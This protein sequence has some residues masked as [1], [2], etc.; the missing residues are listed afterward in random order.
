MTNFLTPVGSQPRGLVKIN[1]TVIDGWL[2]FDVDNNS[3]FSADTFRLTLAAGALP[4]TMDAV[5]FCAQ[6]DMYVELFIGFP[7]DPTNYGPQDLTSWIYGQ[8]DEIDYDPVNNTITLTGRDLTRVFIDTKTTQ[9]W[10]NLTSSQIAT[11]LAQ[12][13]G[14]TPVVTAT[15]IKAG[16]LYEIDHVN[17]TDERS[18]W[19][20]LNYLANAEGFIVYVRGQSLYFQPAPA[21]NTTP[22]Q[23]VWTPP[24]SNTGASANFMHVNFKRALTVS[25]GIQ[26]IVRSWNKKQAKGFVAKF[27]SNV[28]TIQVGKSTV[29]AGVQIYSK[30]VANLDQ[31]TADQYAQNWYNQLVQHE[32]RF[33]NLRMPG[34]NNLDVTSLISLT[35]TGTVFDQTYYP[36]SINRSIS[37]DG[38]YQMTV[39]AKNH[40]PDS[41]VGTL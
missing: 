15:T 23:I 21:P 5:W 9:K 25:R 22:Y 20:I 19:D 40:S 17:V 38:G 34:D 8:T 35:G 18:E 13:H 30:T 37:F 6:Q 36:D 31:A 39:A 32:M 10:Q 2:D 27:P 26:V 1:G 24:S 29:G 11:Q 28:K 14:L 33:D 16:K 41:Q 4:S 12:S 3:F 7:N